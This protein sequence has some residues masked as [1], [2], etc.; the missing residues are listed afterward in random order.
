MVLI[1]SIFILLL[2]LLGYARTKNYIAPTV[3]S[4]LSWGTVLFL[5][6]TLDHGMQGLSNS[7]LGI[8]VIWN[9]SLLAGAWFFS[10]VALKYHLE[11]KKRDKQFNQSIRSIYYWISVLGTFP[12]LYVAYKQGSTLGEGSFFFNLRMANTGIV[13]TDYNYGIW[14][15]IFTFSFVSFLIELFSYQ[16]GD[17]KKRIYI[18]LVINLLLAVVTMAKSSFFF[19]FLCIL[20]SIMFRKKIATRNLLLVF[21]V[22]FLFLSLLQL[23]RASESDESN[24]VSSMFYTYTFGGVPALDEILTADSHSRQWGK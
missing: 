17:G 21:G 22:L 20:F 8:I 14:Q 7:V 11:I 2:A 9:L 3:L 6:A 1:T 10:E 16:K 4:P 15:Y 13:E 12:L 23:L 18:L 19:L 5:Y 24:V